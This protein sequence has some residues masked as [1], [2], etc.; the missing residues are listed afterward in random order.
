[1]SPPRLPVS[2]TTPPT[3]T[4][5]LTSSFVKLFFKL[6]AI[7][8]LTMMQQEAMTSLLIAPAIFRNLFRTSLALSYCK[9][10]RNYQLYKNT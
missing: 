5:T 3:R 6:L 8:R 1:M 4:R 9:V 2:S 10:V 7:Y